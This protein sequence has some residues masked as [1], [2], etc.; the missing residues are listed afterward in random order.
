MRKIFLTLLLINIISLYYSKAQNNE[1]ENY[2]L[3]EDFEEGLVYY[4]NGQQ[5]TATLNYDMLGQEFLFINQAEDNKIMA[6]AEPD[7]VTLVKIGERMFLHDKRLVREVL[8]TEPSVLVAYK[9]KVKSRG[10]NAGYGGYS[11][12][13]AID[14][15]HGIQSGGIYHKLNT[16]RNFI[17]SKVEHTYHIVY[18][19]KK[20]TF[21]N[22]KSFLKIFSKHKD[23]LKEYIN[24]NKINFSSTE[25]VVVLCNHAFSLL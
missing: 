10:K 14:N 13:S 3:L 2:Y 15:I 12:T 6:F 4:K 20:H 16:N 18:N 22:E 21:F 17:F 1:T 8:Q 23:S 24:E 19:K 11:E 9:A 25:Q 5:F 7:M